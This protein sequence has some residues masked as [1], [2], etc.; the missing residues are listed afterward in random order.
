MK[1]LLHLLAV[2][3]VCATGFQAAAGNSRAIALDGVV[4]TRDLGGLRTEDG[5]SVKPGLLIRSGEIDHIS[6]TGKQTLDDIGVA[7][8]IDLRTTKEATTDPAA[9]AEGTGPAR[10]NFPLLERESAIIE[11]M[12]HQIATGTAEPDWMDQSFSD[13]FDYIPTDYTSEI[14]QVFDILLATPPEQSVLYHCSGGKDR[15]GVV[16]AVLLSVLGVTE[17]DIEAD[18]MMSNE[19]IQ[20][21]ATAQ[22]IADKLNA[23]NNTSMTAQDVW[24]SVGV[25]SQYLEVFYASIERDYGDM[26]VY[27]ARGLGLTADEVLLLQEKYLEH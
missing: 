26:D 22:A 24:P 3:V 5:R 20:P 18:F 11:D 14:R 19:L 10:Y 17:E 13:T 7:A 9:W 15:T 16:T 1:K 27:V 4:N 21:D 25:R 12:R 2:F 8:V 6:E 23:R